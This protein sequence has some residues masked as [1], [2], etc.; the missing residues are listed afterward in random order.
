VNDQIIGYAF[1][2]FENDIGRLVRLKDTDDTEPFK[3]QGEN[4]EQF[5]R[6]VQAG[7]W[8]DEDGLA[9]FGADVVCFMP[10]FDITKPDLD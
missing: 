9:V 2:V 1:L 7:V 10:V 6:R 3:G 5:I 4:D 8:F